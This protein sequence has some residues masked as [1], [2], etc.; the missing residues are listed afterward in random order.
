MSATE[1]R[2]P[3]PPN[4]K[5]PQCGADLPP[6]VLDGLCPACLLRQGAAANTVPVATFSPPELGTLARLF[7]QLE[8]IALI[9]TGGMGAVYKARQRELDRVVALKILPPAVGESPAFAERFTR[10]AR[11]LARLSHPGIV[12]IHDFGRVEGLYYFIMEYVDGLNLRQLLQAGRIAPREALAIVPQICDAL[13]YAHDHGI[14]H[15]DIKPENILLDRQ[16]RVKVAD[17]GLA[18]LMGGVETLTAAALTLEDTLTGAGQVMGTPAYMAPEQHAHP[19]EVDHRA[20]IYSLGVVF[21]QMLTGQ[22]PGQP[23]ERPSQKVTI[24]VRLDAVVLRTLEHLP[25]RRYQQVSEVKTMVA[26]LAGSPPPLPVQPDPAA[27]VRRRRGLRQKAVVFVIAASCAFT[28]AALTSWRRPS[29]AQS[30]L[31][32][33]A[34]VGFAIAAYRHARAARETA[35]LPPTAHARH[36]APEA[37]V[38]QR[39]GWGG[40]AVVTVIHAAISLVAVALLAFTVPKFSAIFADLDL[41]LPL[42]TRIVLAASDF[43]Q[44]GGFLLLPLL[45][46]VNFGF[47]CVLQHLGG[48]RA[49]VGWGVAGTLI[50]GVLG[51]ALPTVVVF[52]PLRHTIEQVNSPEALRRMRTPDVIGAGIADP[53][54]PWAWQ[55]LERRAKAG[56]L[57]PADAT[58]LLEGLT[59][60]LRREHSDGYQ[61]TLPWLNSLLMEINRHELANEWKAIDFLVAFHGNPVCEPLPRVRVGQRA[62]ELV[63]RWAAP[64]P[65]ISFGIKLLNEM[66]TITVDG[67]PV[68][69]RGHSAYCDMPSFGA[70]LEL[71]LLAAG[72][73]VVRC[74]MVSAL[75]SSDAAVQLPHRAP[76]KEWPPSKSESIRSCEA[77]L[78]IYPEDAVLVSLTTDPALDPVANGLIAVKTAIVRAKGSGVTLVVRLEEEK[79]AGGPRFAAAFD[80]QVRLGD[81]RHACGSFWWEQDGEHRTSGGVLGAELPSLD[82]RIREADFVLTPNAKMVEG[83]PGVDRIWGREVVFRHVALDRQDLAPRSQTHVFGPV[84][85]RELHGLHADAQAC[86]LDLDCGRFFTPPAGVLGSL[87]SANWRKRYQDSA[88]EQWVRTNGVDVALLEAGGSITAFDGCWRSDTGGNEVPWG[89]TS[90]AGLVRIAEEYQVQ[91]TSG[92]PWLT[93]AAIWSGCGFWFRTREGRIGLGEVAGTTDDPRRVKLRYKLV[94]RPAATADETPAT[95]LD[96]GSLATVFDVKTGLQRGS[97]TVCSSVELELQD[98]ERVLRTHADGRPPSGERVRVPEADEMPETYLVRT[99]GGRHGYLQI[100]GLTNTPAS[101]KIWYRLAENADATA[102]AGPETPEGAFSLQPLASVA[103]GT[104]SIATNTPPVLV[105]GRHGDLTVRGAPVS[106]ERVPAALREAGLSAN[107]PLVVRAS[108]RADYANVLAAL[109]S[110]RDADFR[111]VALQTAEGD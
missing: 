56:R 82:P 52:M 29:S 106:L 73:H 69:W 66:R 2:Q 37:A 47:C 72:R 11:A 4:P 42:V 30:A 10:E 107:S 85:E 111:N 97:T 44:H 70:E 60:W 53:G 71:P 27:A 45:W 5:C 103:A 81:A 80:V 14:V 36:G 34:A 15:R 35:P 104:P 76:S 7:P 59:T 49:L 62:A 40:A 19:A 46:A 84:I 51:L 110:L 98:F 102:S 13:Q 20:D 75:V 88:A 105:V 83:R 28:S 96:L 12:T 92:P 6:G 67:L 64:Q 74:E 8:L 77:E 79:W 65:P 33:L 108:A 68:T 41:S 100:A 3:K 9:G 87:A 26:T 32:A 24:D 61:G 54:Q 86:L 90:A 57:M 94:A 25:E 93:T 109:Q 22:L 89:T 23:I 101:V 91:R 50:A 95:Y 39:S 18:K 99:V 78:N 17:F 58:Q 1:A 43:V 48:R 31:W 63:C 38:R 21:Y 55:E 16:G